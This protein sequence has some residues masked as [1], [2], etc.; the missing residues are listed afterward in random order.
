MLHKQLQDAGLNETEAKIYLATLELGET[1]VGRIADKSGIK[2]TTIYLSLENLIKKG[3]IS[4]IK[5]RG[6]GRRK[7]TKDKAG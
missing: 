5:K 2:R 1:N 6:N 7:N 4:M 3:L